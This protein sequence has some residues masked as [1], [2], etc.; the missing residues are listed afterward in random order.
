MTQELH[1]LR[2][3]LLLQGA[4]SLSD[5]DLLGVILASPHLARSLARTTWSDLGRADLLSL[6]RFRSVRAAQVLAL[7]ELSRRITASPLHL[8]EPLCCS[9]QVAAAYG[10]R[11]AGRK[12]EVFIVIALNAKH[13]V[14]SEHEVARGTLTSVEVDPRA[15]FRGLVRDGAA[16]MLAIHNHPSGDPEPSPDDRVLCARLCEVGEL[17]SVAVLDFVI[18]GAEGMV[19]FADRGWL[20]RS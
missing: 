20:R 19:S 17:L 12:Q 16:A 4:A 15:V 5:V 14:I 10:P 18:V 1:A 7:V 2:Q 8:S 13:R 11:L 6:P 3:R 9:E